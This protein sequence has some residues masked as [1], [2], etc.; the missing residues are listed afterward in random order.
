MKKRLLKIIMSLLITSSVLSG[1]SDKKVP[2]KYGSE[3]QEPDEEDMSMYQEESSDSTDDT[4]DK[5]H[6]TTYENADYND[7]FIAYME[8]NGYKNSNYV[9]SPVSLRAAMALAISGADN[10]TK[11][12]LLKAM[13]FE[14]MEA[15]NTWY[16]ELSESA[17]DSFDIQNAIW[18][19]TDTGMLLSQEYIDNLNDTYGAFARS[20]SPD[21]I[22]DEVNNWI[23]ES[24]KGLI[25]YISDDLSQSDLILLN[26]MYLK[27][28]WASSFDENLTIINNFTTWSGD[29]VTKEFMNQ[30]S[31]FKYYEDENSKFIVMPMEGNTAAVFILG[32]TDNVLDKIDEATYEDVVVSLPK[33]DLENTYEGEELINFCKERGAESAFNKSADFSLMGTDISF[34]IDEILQKDKIVIDETGVT[35]AA[36]TAISTKCIDT[37]K[38]EEYKEFNANKPFKFMI[39]SGEDRPQLLFYGQIAK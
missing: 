13:G 29:T 14:N 15:M 10:N 34:I 32:D 17:T 3:E 27:S 6:I 37:A 4:S 21:L 26:T 23:N 2:G 20:T 31:S 24:T 22:T 16:E 1:C 18:T 25:P 12:E 19:N 9:C 39:I 5:D 35:A 36:A 28:S 7:A 33:F 38:K 30:K 11:D 8:N